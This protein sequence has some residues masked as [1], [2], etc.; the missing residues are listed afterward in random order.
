MAEDTVSG[1]STEDSPSQRLKKQETRLLQS[2]KE[3]ESLRKQLEDIKS[4]K[5]N[6]KAKKNKSPSKSP[7]KKKRRRI[8][9]LSS[10]DTGSNSDTSGSTSEEEQQSDSEKPKKAVRHSKTVISRSTNNMETPNY[11]NRHEVH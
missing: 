6:K 8:V 3:N 2:Q 5:K 1:S 11:E 4:K 7:V 10:S 9:I